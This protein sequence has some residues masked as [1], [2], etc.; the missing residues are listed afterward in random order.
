[1]DDLI[2][3]WTARLDQAEQVAREAARLE[4]SHWTVEGRWDDDDV[5]VVD[6]DGRVMHDNRTKISKVVSL[7]HRGTAN[8]IALN[9][10]QAALAD[11]TAD[12]AL[13]ARYERLP[14]IEVREIGPIGAR[15]GLALAIRIRAA[16]FSD[17][18][19]YK[20]EWAP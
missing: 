5:N 7:I 9:D 14:A 12:R 17:H 10:P 11:I 18:P 15:P 1:M 6:N 19:D 4:G 3:F 16:R 2:A 13:I 8:H 20:Q